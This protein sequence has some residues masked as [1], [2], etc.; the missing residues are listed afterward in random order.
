MLMKQT[1][2]NFSASLDIQQ[3]YKTTFNT[4]YNEWLIPIFVGFWDQITIKNHPPFLKIRYEIMQCHNDLTTHTVARS[5]RVVAMQQLCAHRAQA[6][7]V[8]EALT[9]CRGRGAARA[10]A[11]ARARVSLGWERRN[12]MK[13]R[14]Q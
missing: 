7:V 2:C 1:I 10:A 11:A 5:A 9:Q 14:Q 13:S 4:M 6:K 3:K 12:S 8:V